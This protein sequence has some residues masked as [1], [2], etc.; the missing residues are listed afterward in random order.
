MVKTNGRTKDPKGRSAL[1]DLFADI[2][3]IEAH[4]FSVFLKPNPL[5]LSRGVH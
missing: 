5:V 4:L 2:S 1:T 3:C